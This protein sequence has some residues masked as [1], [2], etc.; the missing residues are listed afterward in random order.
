MWV[1]YRTNLFRVSPEHLRQATSEE[2]ASQDV[3]LREFEEQAVNTQSPGTQTGFYD[4][5]EQGGT[6]FG[7]TQAAGQS[8]SAHGEPEP[9]RSSPNSPER[10]ESSSR[11]APAEEPVPQ[12]VPQSEPQEVFG[13]N[14]EA[15]DTPIPDDEESGALVLVAKKS[16]GEGAKELDPKKFDEAERQLFDKSDLKEITS[17]REK[18]SMDELTEEQSKE[19]VAN[20][21]GRIIHGRSR[22]LRTNKAATEEDDPIAKS[23]I[24]VPGHNDMDIGKF[25][26]DAPTA[27]QLALYMMLVITAGHDWILQRFDVETAFLNGVPLGREVYARAPLGF[28]NVNPNT[29]WKINK[30]V[31]GLQEAPRLWWLK[32]RGDLI[33]MGWIELR[34][35][36]AV[37]IL[38]DEKGKLIGILVIHVDDGLCAGKGRQFDQALTRLYDRLPIKGQT[39]STTFSGRYIEQKEDCSFVVSQPSYL[40]DVAPI[41]IAKERKKQKDSP[42]TASEKTAFRSLVQK[43]A[44]PSRTTN[45]L[46]AFEVSNFQ[47]TVEQATV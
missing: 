16:D 5:S 31:F 14:Q 39:G 8:R 3:V 2:V 15:I 34:Y 29:L 47:Q 25:R 26:S 44:W 12:S 36:K 40:K 30:G 17:W 6:P 43:L 24:I 20:K 28:K 45:P 1:S 4:I 37:F 41:E 7:G 21:P 42:V 9:E 11:A 23:R 27:P 10:N 19:V 35:I 38:L 22:V 46:L 13:D 33:E 32:F 18:E